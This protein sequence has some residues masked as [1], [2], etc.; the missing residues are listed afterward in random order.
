VKEVSADTFAVPNEGPVEVEV[1]V[2]RPLRISFKVLG[3]LFLLRGTRSSK[4][5]DD[6]DAFFES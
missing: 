1:T 5:E 2:P 6:D 4:A 3:V